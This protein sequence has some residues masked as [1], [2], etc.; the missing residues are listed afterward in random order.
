M[1]LGIQ[2]T[3]VAFAEVSTDGL[4]AGQLQLRADLAAHPDPHRWGPDVAVSMMA[5]MPVIDGDLIPARPIDRVAAGASAERDLLVGSNV[6]E[7]NAFLVPSGA[8]DHIP[9]QVVSGIAAAYGLPIDTALTTYRATHPGASA[10]ELLAAIQGDWYFRIPA[11]NLAEAHAASA[12]TTY[13]YEFAWRSPQFDGR[14]G[15]CHGLD[16]PFVFDTLGEGTEPL[17]GADPPQQLADEMHSAWVA[18]ARTGDCGWP[19]YDHGRR[20]TMRFGGCSR[21][22]DD[23][24]PA[25][26]A[27]W[28]RGELT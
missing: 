2:P 27:L 6:D 4:L 26:R 7:W 8:I 18:F 10:G 17:L 14:L 25:E 19:K 21:I 22:V 1:L 11:L 20:A 28:R 16:V 23:P 5:W 13:M 15:A 3:Q 9:D 12:A 24:R